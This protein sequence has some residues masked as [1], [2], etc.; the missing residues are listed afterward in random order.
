M[1]A[2]DQGVTLLLWTGKK[3][4]A[5]VPYELA[6]AL[7][8]GEVTIDAGTQSQGFQL[9]FQLKRSGSRDYEVFEQDQLAPLTRLQLGVR[10][11]A[12]VELL[13]DGVIG[14]FQLTPGTVTGVAT[15][16]I[17]GRDL[18]QIMDLNER[19]RQFHNRADS[20]I[21]S[22]ILGAYRST[23]SLTSDVTDTAAPRSR[24]A[25]T[26]NQSGTD[27]QYLRQLA[28]RNGFVFY[29]TPTDVGSA[30]AYFGPDK[31]VPQSLPPLSLHFGPASN[32][33]SL[34][35]A[36]DPLARSKVEGMG[37]NQAEGRV[38][39]LLPSE[40]PRQPLSA[41]PAEPLRTVLRR[42]IAKRS[43]AEGRRVL[44]A[45]TRNQPD[46]VTAEGEVDIVRYGEVLRPRRRIL[47]RGAG[48]SYDGE[49]RIRRVSHQFQR[50]Q[51][52]QRFSLSREGL[53]VRPELYR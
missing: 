11:G 38:S 27:L 28:E 6:I 12:R 15:L 26:P 41:M 8:S 36:F 37:I 22:E 39:Q 49:Y 24:T 9:S 21:V 20:S 52:V 23:Y 30:S 29:V 40:D 5:P 34:N 53:G 43:P 32:V 33:R 14:H 3:N 7:V 13:F 44:D 48:Y 47:V 50:G 1:L 45:A 19:K 46:P 31:D 18:S 42:D 2:R 51:Y 25:R 10:I 16:A 17:T 35:F 4:V